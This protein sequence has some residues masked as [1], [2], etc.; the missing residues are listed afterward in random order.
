MRSCAVYTGFTGLRRS[1]RVRKGLH[2]MPAYSAVK[3]IPKSAI[4]TLPIDWLWYRSS[5]ASFLVSGK[6]LISFS[7]NSSLIF[8]P[9]RSRNLLREI[10]HHEGLEQNKSS[11]IFEE[12]NANLA[13]Q[14]IPSNRESL[15]DHAALFEGLRALAVRLYKRTLTSDALLHA[16]GEEPY[17]PEVFGLSAEDHQKL[18]SAA[19]GAMDLDSAEES[20]PADT[21]EPIE[22]EDENEDGSNAIGETSADRPDF[23]IA[24]QEMPLNEEGVIVDEAEWEDVANIPATVDDDIPDGD[25]RDVMLMNSLLLMRDSFIHVELCSAVREGDIGRVFEMI[26]VSERHN[27]IL[28]LAHHLRQSTI[29]C[30]VYLPC[31]G[32]YQLHCRV[33]RAGM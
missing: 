3:S 9:S 4:I 23:G 12:L 24:V 16:S 6:S 14:G 11:D 5:P 17:T 29:A 25:N 31:C 1:P 30:A 33:P 18:F 20:T 26:K 15:H 28:I 13:A 22:N 21:S 19:Q 32:C 27:K 7:C 10:R 2:A 8:G